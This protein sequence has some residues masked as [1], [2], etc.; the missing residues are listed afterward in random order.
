MCTIC[1]TFRPYQDDCDYGVDGA[2]TVVTETTDAAMDTSTIYSMMVGDTFSGTVESGGDRDWVA[3]TLT[4]GEI[5]DIDL[6]GSPSGRGTLGDPVMAVYDSSGTYLDGNDDGGNG[7]ESHLTFTAGYTG[8]YYVMG[9]GYSTETGTYEITVASQNADPEPAGVT[10]ASLDTMADYLTDG[11]WNATGQGA[12][13]FNTASSNQITVNLTGLTADG[14]QLARWA[15]EAWEAVADLNFVETSGSAQMTF[16]D[17]NSGASASYSRSGGTTNYVDINIS[18][19]W[20]NSYGTEISSYGFQT[21]LHEIGHGLGLGHM[22][23]YNGGATYGT[24]NEFLNDSW[25]LSVMSYFSQTE[26]TW[27]TGASYAETVTAMVA[28]VVAIQNLYGAAEAG[29]L[30]DGNTTYGVGHTLGNSWL[31]QLFDAVNGVI[32]SNGV[33][34]DTGFSITLTDI[35]GYDIVNF[36]GDTT[37]QTVN[38]AAEG[39]STVMGET[40]NMVIARGTVIEEYHAG[41]GNDTVDGN[42]VDNLLRGN[43]GNDTLRGLGGNDI[44][45]G[46]LGADTLDGGEGDD[47]ADY[48]YSGVGITVDLL[49]SAQN[50]GGAAGDTLISIENVLGTSQ[51]DTFRGNGKLNWFW[52]SDGDDT[53]DGRGGNDKLW[54]EG[55]DDTIDGS[56]G[57]D[58]INGGGGS[59]LI[60]GGDDN[61]KLFG[62]AGHDTIQGGSGNDILHGQGGND[63]LFGDAG[64]DTMTGGGGNDVFYFD[65]GADRITDFAGDRLRFDESLWG[66]TTISK[67]DALSYGSVIGSDTVFDFGNGNTLTMEDYTDLWGLASSLGF[68]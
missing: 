43:G 31:G 27:L 68:Y 13:K 1:Q 24:D 35:G 20:L 18:T 59:D 16:D 65:G 17:N 15:L 9:R 60:L 64:N 45:I 37:H 62:N 66:G 22:G 19:N 3:I 44:L 29:S 63:H 34:N 33:W 42:A 67:S 58:R 48:Q 38:L 7:T 40:K 11:Y 12:H 50:A 10:E 14:Q 6:F 5:Y 54:G 23:N 41:S 49:D 32:P 52:G 47:T 26:N 61:D 21:Y 4:A 46:D 51:A 39:V 30:T 55:G 8:T 25:Q 57:R 36:S 2:G 56:Q 28:D 53:V